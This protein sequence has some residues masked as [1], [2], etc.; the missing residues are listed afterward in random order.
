MI[1][2]EINHNC[3]I[4]TTPAIWNLDAQVIVV[5]DDAKSRHALGQHPRRH[6]D[7]GQPNQ[8]H[9]RESVRHS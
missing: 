3:G 9:W 8:C 1:H 4:F 5:A 7:Q 2:V 6:N